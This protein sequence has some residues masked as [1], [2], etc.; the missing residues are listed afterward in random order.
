[1]NLLRRL[2]RLDR[3][4]APGPPPPTPLS[5]AH[6]DAGYRMYWTKL[7]WDWDAERRA[8]IAQ[9]VMETASAPGFEENALTRR[10]HVPELDEQAHSGA[11]LLALAEVLRA[12]DAFESSGADE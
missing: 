7:A 9:R 8:T 4:A 2:L 10:F 1:M 5:K 11:S 3:P 12:L 6:I